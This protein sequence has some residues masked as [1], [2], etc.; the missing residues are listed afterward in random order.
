M[1]NFAEI[2]GHSD[3]TDDQ[4]L[5]YSDEEM[6]YQYR[7]VRRSSAS[8]EEEV[9]RG[10]NIGLRASSAFPLEWEINRETRVGMLKPASYPY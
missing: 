4:S 6:D 5:D 2:P 1:T 8:T 7:R 9:D 10:R 3:S